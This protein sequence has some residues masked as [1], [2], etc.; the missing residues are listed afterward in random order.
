[1]PQWFRDR[2][3]DDTTYPD[4]R[5]R[6]AC[7]REFA[8]LLLR[9]D[10]HVV[11]VGGRPALLRTYHWAE[12]APSEWPA[13]LELEVSFTYAPGHPYAPDEVRGVV[14]TLSFSPMP[15]ARDRTRDRS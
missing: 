8:A 9:Y 2:A 13:E 7:P 10:H 6:A 14:D 15:I 4:E 1:M 11:W 3:R 5:R 12:M